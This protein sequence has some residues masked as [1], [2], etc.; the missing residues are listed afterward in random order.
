[1]PRDNFRPLSVSQHSDGQPLLAALGHAVKHLPPE[2]WES[3][4][5]EGN[6]LDSERRPV[7]LTR[8]VRAGERYL[9][10]SQQQVEPD[11]NFDLQFLHEDEV[12][13]VLDKP[14]PLPMHAGG[15][16]HRNTLQYVLEEIYRP[17]KPRPA[18][19]LDA[20]TT[21]VLVVARTRHFAGR[22]QPLFA[23]GEV[24]KRYLVRVLGHPPQDKFSCEA[25]IGVCRR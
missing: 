4:C 8:I 1:M 23:A 22:L 7:D 21:G 17:Q 2:Y 25:P 12:L 24:R 5:R 11:V 16:F 10:R 19:R 14:A 6:L 9:H 13:L 20:N 3:E 18:H 15:R